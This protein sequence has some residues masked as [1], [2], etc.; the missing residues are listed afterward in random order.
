[1]MPPPNGGQGWADRY[2]PGGRLSVRA[3]CEQ[4]LPAGGY[5][6]EAV[7]KPAEGSR[8]PGARNG[9]AK[10]SRGLLEASEE[11]WG[12]TRCAGEASQRL[13]PT[14]GYGRGPGRGPEG[15]RGR[16]RGC[17]ETPRE[18]RGNR[19]PKAAVAVYDR[20][21]DPSRNGSQ[22]GALAAT[23]RIM[24]VMRLEVSADGGE[25]LTEQIERC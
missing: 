17:A 25:A 12:R 6:M 9:E 21:T 7:E 24:A 16:P 18:V 14:P 2:C 15:P 8:V 5:S 3:H 19:V 1:M 20:G 22:A 13:P 23:R 4:Y 10:R 11:S